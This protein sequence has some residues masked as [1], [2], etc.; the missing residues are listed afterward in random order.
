[1]IKD[2]VLDAMVAAGC[3]AEQIAAAIKADRSGASNADRQ[4]RYRERKKG[5][6]VTAVAQQDVTLRNGDVSDP[7]SPPRRKLPHTP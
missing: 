4:R 6:I 5:V 3:T 1:M 7:A 2:A